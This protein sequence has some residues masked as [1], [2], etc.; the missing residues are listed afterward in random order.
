MEVLQIGLVALHLRLEVVAVPLKM[1]VLLVL[2]P[3]EAETHLVEPLVQIL[4][5]VA[6]EALTTLFME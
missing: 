4:V 1:L 3:L 6:A 2:A 5:V